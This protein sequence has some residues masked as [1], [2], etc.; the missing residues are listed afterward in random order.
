MN[1]QSK[2]AISVEGAKK[3][4]SRIYQRPDKVEN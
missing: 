2:D 4:E 3:A 1:M